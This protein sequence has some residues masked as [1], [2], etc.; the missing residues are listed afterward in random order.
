M[1]DGNRRGAEPGNRAGKEGMAFGMRRLFDRHTRVA[2]ALSH[3]DTLDIKRQR[4]RGRQRA[5]ELLVGVRVR[6]SK[7]MVQVRGAHKHGAFTPGD[8]AEREQ[9]RDRIRATGQRHSDTA[10]RGSSA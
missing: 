5:A 8:L 4:Q 1:G 9:Q 10:S 6:A 7:L 2:R 3:V